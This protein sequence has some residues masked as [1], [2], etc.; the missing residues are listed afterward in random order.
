MAEVVTDE[1]RR[2]GIMIYRTLKINNSF[3]RHFGFIIVFAVIMNALIFS[4]PVSGRTQKQKTFGSPDEAVKA[5]VTAIKGNDAGELMLIFGPD[6]K[7][8][9]LSGDEVADKAGKE[10][11]IIAY[12][13]KNRLENF[14]G[15]RAILYVGNND[16]PMPIPIVKKG[17]SWHF[18]SQDGKREILQRRI[19]RNELNTIQ[20]CKAYVDAQMDYVSRDYNGD[21]LFE[22]AQKF[23]STPEKKDGLYWETKEDEEKS[24]L[25]IFFANAAREGYFPKDGKNKP[26]PFH[27]YYYRILKEQ[28]EGAPGGA[29]SYV[30]K[31]KM[32]NG[33]ALV[34][35]PAKYGD[36][37]VMTF[38]VNKDGMVYQKDLGVNTAKIV[39]NIRAYDPDKTW[40][41]AE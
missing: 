10:N 2:K 32:I 6:I 3:K 18:N 23:L 30:V 26:V 40:K 36:S 14:S 11:F 28:G 24:P 4:S 1:K 9:F 15:N 19:G 13:E 17:N 39:K 29:C 22:Y 38:I 5:M 7:G 37:G 12:N 27:G 31:G 33:F 16:W 41:K 34:A 21:G 20:T 8:L 25:G 35:Y